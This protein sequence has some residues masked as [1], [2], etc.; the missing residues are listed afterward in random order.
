MSQELMTKKRRLAIA[1]YGL[2]T[3]AMGYSTLAL[4]SEPAQAAECDCEAYAADASLICSLVYPPCPDAVPE[5]FYCSGDQ[6]SWDCYSW[7]QP[8]PYCGT[9][10][11]YCG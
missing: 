8:N 10:W 11:T 9:F 1:L 5:F 4:Y 7:N 3:S 6:T 2:L